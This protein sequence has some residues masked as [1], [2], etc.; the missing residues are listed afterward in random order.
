MESPDPNEADD[1]IVSVPSKAASLPMDK[2]P[3]NLPEPLALI[4]SPVAKE[5]LMLSPDPN[6]A[7]PE[8]EADPSIPDAAAETLDPTVTVPLQDNELPNRAGSKTLWVPAVLIPPVILQPLPIITPARIDRPDPVFTW[9]VTDEEPETRLEPAAD[10]PP[11]IRPA[12]ATE[13]LEQPTTAP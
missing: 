4:E 6:M 8:I 13:R 10:R 12:E 1:L 9:P 11:A 5:S 7:E 2:L 3:P